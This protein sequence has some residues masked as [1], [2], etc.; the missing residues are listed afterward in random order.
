V[1]ER[2]R[3]VQV[4]EERLL[5]AVEKNCCEIVFLDHVEEERQRAGS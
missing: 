1:E 2:I 3:S 4:V 5:A